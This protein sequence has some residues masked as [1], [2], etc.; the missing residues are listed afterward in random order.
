MVL[1]TGKVHAFF[2]VQCSHNREEEL[3]QEEENSQGVF[4]KV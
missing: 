4:M 1:K 2:Y 3:I